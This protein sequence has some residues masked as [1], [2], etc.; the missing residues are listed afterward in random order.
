M[1]M[2]YRKKNSID[3]LYIGKSRLH[4]NKANLIQTLH[5]VNALQNLNINVQLI[6]PPIKKRLKV[7]ERLHEIG[8]SQNLKVNTSR[9][10]HPNW[11]FFNYNLF[12]YANKK[13]L[14]RQKNIYVRSPDL[15]LK[16]IKMKINH[17]LEIHNISELINK[18]NLYYITKAHKEHIIKWLF[19]ISQKTSE[20]MI[21]SGANKN[22]IC[23]VPSGVNCD[24]YKDIQELNPN[25]KE[26]L[27]LGYI[28]TIS[29][30][31]GLGIIQ[32]LSY[33]Q[34]GDIHLVG[35][36][37]DSFEQTPGVKHTKFI[38]HSKI[39]FFYEDI[40]ILLLPY[41]HNL[42]HVHSISPMKLFEGMAAGRI[43][44][45]SNIPPIREVIRH[46]YTG[47]LVDPENVQDWVNAI[48]F[49]NKDRNFASMLAKN[50]K[51]HAQNYSW[52]NRAYHIS[53]SLKLL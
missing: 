15:S 14:M 8:V 3:I 43:I 47:I 50:A 16:L 1:T 11:S 12:F 13:K 17:S 34:L 24:L 28:G 9:L 21:K 29:Y 53:H 26:K 27:K 41:Q 20:K 2:R 19:P 7:Q 31:R 44:I 51:K 5:T 52:E 46:N 39:H 42:P 4:K 35:I 49:L 23:V 38:P 6:L 30:S 33:C 32:K 36:K 40:D 10:L 45:A 18:K 22:R 48:T 25:K 37:E